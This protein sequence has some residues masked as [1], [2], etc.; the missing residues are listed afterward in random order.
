M[1]NEEMMRIIYKISAWVMFAGAVTGIIFSGYALITYWKNQNRILDQFLSSVSLLDQTLTTTHSG[2]SVVDDAIQKAR[3]D[4]GMTRIFLLQTAD[5]VGNTSPTLTSIA[6]L[7]GEDL[8]A[9]VDDTQTSLNS[10]E[11]SAKLIDDTLKIISALPFIGSRYAPSQPLGESI[12][13]ISTTLDNLPASLTDIQ[14]GLNST[15]EDLDDIETSVSTVAESIAEIDTD[16]ENASAVIKEY[17]TITTEL[18]DNLVVFQQDLPGWIK[19]FSYTI[20]FLFAWISIASFGLF[21]A[22]TLMLKQSKP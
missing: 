18:H 2:L 12:A 19:T 22:G 6:D 20:S 16:L 7:F 1:K 4:I 15:V 11:S 9:I 17:Q 5:A 14:D 21:G 3:E 13:Q 10:A 8:I